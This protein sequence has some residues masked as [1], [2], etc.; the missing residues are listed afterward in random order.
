MLRSVRNKLFN[1]T[2]SAM[3]GTVE[4]TA[5]NKPKYKYV[6]RRPLSVKVSKLIS[7]RKKR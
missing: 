3:N 2:A 6:L 5:L 4:I 1:L 7:S